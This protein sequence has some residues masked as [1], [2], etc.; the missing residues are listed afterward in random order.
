MQVGAIRTHKLP[1]PA[2][3]P[4]DASAAG[5]EGGVEWWY[6]CVQASTRPWPVCERFDEIE[7]R[8]AV[9][10]CASSLYTRV[11][12]RRRNHRECEHLERAHNHVCLL[13]RICTN[14]YQAGVRMHVLVVRVRRERVLARAD[15]DA[16][17]PSSDGIRSAR[18]CSCHAMPC[19][20]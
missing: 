9:C 19:I 6:G 16:R 18:P 13:H 8:E 7:A 3:P 4:H 12:R 5:L 10:V 14:M 2:A 17:D 11:H 1:C 15:M 20:P